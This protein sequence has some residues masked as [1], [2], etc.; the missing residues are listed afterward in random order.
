MG[1]MEAERTNVYYFSVLDLTDF[2]T[3]MLGVCSPGAL[4]KIHNTKE[5]LI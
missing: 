2:T 4:Q 5:A 1:V 3:C